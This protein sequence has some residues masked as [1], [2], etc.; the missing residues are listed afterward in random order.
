MS[1]KGIIGM[2]WGDE[3]KGKITHLLAENAD[4]IV[5]YQGGNNAGHTIKFG[6]KKFVLHLIPSGAL[7]K[8]KKCVLANGVVINPVSLIEEIEFLEN[9]GIPVRENLLISSRA[10]IILPYHGLIDEY[11]E[12]HCSISQKI[13]TTKKG[14]GVSY[15]DKVNRIGVRVCDYLNEKIFLQILEQNLQLKKEY[16]SNNI[17]KINEIRKQIISDRQKCLPVIK[18]IVAAT[19][20]LFARSISE[21]KSIL[22]EGA[23]GVMLDV[24]FGTY[25]FVTSS[26]PSGGGISSGAG[27]APTLIDEIIGITKA[28]TTR[29][30]EGPFPT[31][32]KDESGEQLRK[33]GFEYGSTT[34]RP[35]RC[36][37]FDAVVVRY[38]AILNNIKNAAF[39]KIDVL[40]DFDEIKICYAYKYNDLTYEYVPADNEIL[41]SCEPLYIT[42]PGWK[43]P[44]AGIT[45][46]NLL[47]IA[48]QKYIKKLEELTVVKAA[49]ISTGPK[50]E[51]TIVM[52]KDLIL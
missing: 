17:D 29:V 14:I 20:I 1:V 21:N 7:L 36:G 23:Q 35:R 43:T 49:I 38:S 34:G 5:R 45:D 37:W 16:F 39:T 6:D 11:K 22:L 24:D 30:G 52:Q 10:H 4:F 15:S 47:P 8:N 25:P 40:D 18:P 28:Y 32:L 51:E 33:T 46:Y 44:T 48:A 12:E 19:E 27:I 41:A 42:M 2:Q 26:N 31:E 3:G 50:R 9:Q 13:G